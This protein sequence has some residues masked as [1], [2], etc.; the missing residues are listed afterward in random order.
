MHLPRRSLE[1]SLIRCASLCRLVEPLLSFLD[2]RLRLLDTPI[3]SWASAFLLVEFLHVGSATPVSNAAFSLS[4][5]LLVQL[6]G[7]FLRDTNTCPRTLHRGSLS[8][9]L[10]PTPPLPLDSVNNAVRSPRQTSLFATW[11]IKENSAPNFLQ[12]ELPT[13]DCLRPAEAR[14]LSNCFFVS[15]QLA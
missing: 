1:C 6:G 15:D 11:G 5:T 12:A 9:V 4:V 8:R 14:G 13:A 10:V 7:G 3:K 2:V